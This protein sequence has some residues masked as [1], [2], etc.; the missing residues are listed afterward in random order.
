MNILQVIADPKV[1]AAHF[2]TATWTAWLAFLC[3][4][5][6]LPMTSEQLAIYQKHTGRL[7]A[8][9]KPSTEAWLVVG[10]RG[11]KSFVLALIAVFLAA[12]VDWRPFLGPGELGTVM[13]VAADRRQA[14]VI[15]RYVVG[16]LRSVPMLAKLIEGETRESITLR[17]RVTIEIHT[18]SF[19]LTRG[20]TVLAALLDELAFWETNEDASE[21]DVE[22]INAIRPAMATVP[23]AMLLCASSPYARRGALWTAFAKHHG[24][25]GD[26]ILVW[27][28]D[29]RAMNPSVPQSLIDA[30]MADDPAR[31]PAEYGGQFRTDLEAYVAR[32]AAM[33]C[34]SA[35]VFER[36]PKHYTTYRAFCDP[37]G[38]SVDSM[39]LGIGHYEAGKQLIVI[40]AL[41][42]TKPPFSPEQVVGEFAKLLK[43]YRLNKVVS[44]R[45]GGAWVVEQFHKFGIIC[46]PSAKVKSEL[47]VDLLALL[48][49]RRIDL[50]DHPRTFNQLIGLERHTAR[51]GRDRIDHAPGQHDDLINSVA[52]VAS[53]LISKSTYNLDALSDSLP[54]DEEPIEVHRAR[55]WMGVTQERYE[56]IIAPLSFSGA[57][58]FGSPERSRP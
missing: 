45:F 41:R 3:A 25:E 6:A 7:T 15:L 51:F 27:Q 46:E 31:A 12:F 26:P 39:T 23:N 57:R 55:R 10:R 48:N 2:R 30:A 4:L 52:G 8:P 54:E 16:L 20:Y 35:G 43:A 28:A 38:G 13:V 5:F 40:D 36:P 58:I 56:Q 9:T 44:D 1:F 19:K 11:G 37:S 21:P 29:T 50:L 49:S 53:E 47:Y 22:I 14:R 33:A 17:N 18:A 32:E 42:E 34:V 24:K